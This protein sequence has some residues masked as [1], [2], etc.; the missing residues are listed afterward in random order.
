MN[1]KYVIQAM[2]K[3]IRNNAHQE[4]IRCPRCGKV[5]DAEVQHTHPFDSYAH[6]CACGYWITES[7]WEKAP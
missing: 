7:E 3:G 2:G 6:E 5:E 1:V 4:Q